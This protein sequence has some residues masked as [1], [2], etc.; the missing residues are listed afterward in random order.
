MLICS[1]YVVYIGYLFGT[2]KNVQTDFGRRVGYASI[3]LL[4][5]CSVFMQHQPSWL[6][7][8]R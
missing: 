1:H 5:H 7:A 6:R 4:I 3:N 8:G 2:V